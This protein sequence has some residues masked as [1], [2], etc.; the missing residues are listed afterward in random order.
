MNTIQSHV[1]DVTA[2]LCTMAARTTLLL[3]SLADAFGD[4]AYRLEEG[5]SPNPESLATISET[6]GTYLD[7]LGLP[8][9]S[10]HQVPAIVTKAMLGLFGFDTLA[11]AIHSGHPAIGEE[12]REDLH[13]MICNLAPMSLASI[14]GSRAAQMA[15]GGHSEPLGEW[16]VGMVVETIMELGIPFVTGETVRLAAV[17]MSDLLFDGPDMAVYESWVSR[18]CQ[19]IEQ[20]EM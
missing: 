13:L 4:S 1:V 6:I 11:Y 8:E 2:T 18:G 7:F 9:G 16:P 14:A 15:A 19:A 10:G 12:G 17:T 3:P 5:L 20:A